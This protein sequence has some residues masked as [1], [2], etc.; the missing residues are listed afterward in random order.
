MPEKLDRLTN[1][2]LK[3][4]VSAKVT[5]AELPTK[6]MLVLYFLFVLFSINYEEKQY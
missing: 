3:R 4:N 2:F 1:V 5:F 6:T